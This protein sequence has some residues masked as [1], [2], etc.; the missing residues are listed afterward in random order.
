M[1]SLYVIKI[2]GNIIDDANALRQFLNDF[3]QIPY[4]KLLIHG[5]GKLAT[6]LATQLGIETK[7]I[8]GRRITDAETIKIVTMVYA[9]F[10]NKNIV[11]T[12]STHHQ[13]S[14]GICG[15][16]AQAVLA[17][18]RQNATID[19]GFVGDI[20]TV[21]TD[22]FRHLLEQNLVPIIA[23]ITSDKQGN[24]L[25]TNA[26]TMASAIAVALSK[27]YTVKLFYCF[28]KKGLLKDVND[29]NTCI[30]TIA[31][32]DIQQLIE[33]QIIS[34]GMLP[35]VQNIKTA[36][37][38]GVEKVSLCHA[39]DLLDIICENSIFGTTFYQL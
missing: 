30:P 25:N 27:N 6:Q 23:P 32:Q 26:D 39:A 8:D 24:L 38:S 22:F 12:L 7:M 28:E 1:S 9:G 19:Y 13:K 2:G 10:I 20:D 34:D 18:K 29:N 16:D 11:A 36:I 14:I 31:A 15:A 35:K 5:G 21:N 17:H 4:P 33:Q 3:A 37:E